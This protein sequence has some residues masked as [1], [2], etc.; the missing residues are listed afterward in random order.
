MDPRTVARID[1]AVARA[2]RIHP[3]CDNL[4]PALIEELGEV[5]SEQLEGA[6]REEVEAEILDAIAVLI[7]MLEQR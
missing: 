5:A 7:R 3:H 2:R 6:P 1:A 4:W